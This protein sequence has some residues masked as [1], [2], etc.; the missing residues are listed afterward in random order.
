M[1]RA[2][3]GALA[4]LTLL[5]VPPLHAA[6]ALRFI[7]CPVY[8]DSDAGRKSGCWLAEDSASGIRYDVSLSPTKPDWN[9]EILVE[10]RVG[11]QGAAACGGLTL[12]PVRVSILPGACTR[13]S[14]PAEGYPGRVFVLPERNV[15]PLS[16]ARALPPR[17]WTDR[18]FAL[19]FE[20]NRSFAV[21]QLD[22]Y[23]LDQAITYIRAVSPRRIRITGYAA[24]AE[25]LVSGRVIAERA[26]VARERAEM[27]AESLRRLGVPAEKLEVSW[28]TAAQPAAID[29]ADGLAE[30]SRRRVEIEVLL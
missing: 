1:S 18:R 29:G 23:L 11:A 4:A 3:C 16:E 8:R 13:H 25:T 10:G 14:L 26:D 20:W 9:H 22:D 15:R 5:A 2:I 12:E 6:E 27:A 24:T 28:Q 21:Y 19:Q 17:P 30:A 7:A